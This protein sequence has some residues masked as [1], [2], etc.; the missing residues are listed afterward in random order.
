LTATSI[1]PKRST[2]RAT[3]RPVGHVEL[4]RQ[5]GVRM[6]IGQLRQRAWIASGQHDRVA[7]LERR[8]RERATE[9][10]R[11]PRDQPDRPVGI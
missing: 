8:L 9:P 6:T 1:R 5:R 10:P 2:P 4:E 3:G 7:S 11:R